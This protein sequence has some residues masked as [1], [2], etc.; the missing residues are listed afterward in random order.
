MQGT[1]QTVLSLG[2]GVQSVL[3]WWAR[4]A[5]GISILVKKA[6]SVVWLVTDGLEAQ[7]EGGKATELNYML[8]NTSHL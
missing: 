6:A 5:G 3:W 8:N 1:G 4:E 2:V 7:A